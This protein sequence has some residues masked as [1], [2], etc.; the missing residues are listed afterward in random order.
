MKIKKPNFLKTRSEKEADLAV[1]LIGL[2]LTLEDNRQR[3][4]T[5]KLEDESKKLE[6]ESKALENENLALKNQ[7]LE[8][9]KEKEAK[10][11]ENL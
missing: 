5:K 2:A 7:L 10:T 8:L 1:A 6:N 9:Q 11:I 4:K 3:S